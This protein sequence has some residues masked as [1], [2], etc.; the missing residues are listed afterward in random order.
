MTSHY[1]LSPHVSLTRTP[2]GGGILM[3]TQSGTLYALNP[4]AATI[5]TAVRASEGSVSDALTMLA[6]EGQP[7]A[8]EWTQNLMQDLQRRRLMQEVCG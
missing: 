5:L 6:T 4:T 8:S 7:Q 2:E 3:N 1:R